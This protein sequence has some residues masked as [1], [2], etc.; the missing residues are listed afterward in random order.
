M[1]VA[2]ME[3]RD[4]PRVAATLLL[5]AWEDGLPSLCELQDASEHGL[6]LRRLSTPRRMS[7]PGLVLEMS[8][9]DSRVL[10][11]Q[12]QRVREAGRSFAVRFADLSSDEVRTIRRWLRD[13][14]VTVR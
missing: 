10:R 1:E 7:S 13:Q 6:R 8:V 12:A 14:S 11:L 3:R 9:D 2:L 4:T 5:N